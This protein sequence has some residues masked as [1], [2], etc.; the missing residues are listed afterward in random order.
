MLIEKIPSGP[1]STNAYVLAC[2]KTKQAVIV[3]PAPE[4]APLISKFVSAQG[5]IPVSILI[6]H[7][8]W[9]HIGD[10]TVLHALY[11]IPVLIHHDDAPNLIKPGADGLPCWL[12]IPGIQPS[13]YLLDGQKIKFGK[14][15]LEVIY[16]PG[17]SPGGVCFYLPK[18]NA[19]ISGDTLFKG[20]I[21]NLS[22]PTARPH[23]MWDSLKRL[24]ELPAETVVYPGHGPNT[25][26]GEES[27]LSNAESM[28][29]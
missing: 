22:F 5:L 17:H 2:P 14:C 13:G 20:T 19:L 18:E 8:H 29:T 25:T 27:W 11:N 10:V 23:L 9:D 12:N 4:S 15:E 16:T 6:T 24:A 28:F 21:G 26:I 3:D 1:F 7:S